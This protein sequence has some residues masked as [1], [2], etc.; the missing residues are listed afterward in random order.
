MG[1]GRAALV[2]NKHTLRERLYRL[3]LFHAG[4]MLVNTHGVQSSAELEYHPSPNPS[5]FERAWSSRL[6]TSE[7]SVS[8]HSPSQARTEH[9]VATYSPQELSTW[10]I[11]RETS[12]S[13]WTHSLQHW[14]TITQVMIRNGTEDK[15]TSIEVAHSRQALSSV[16]AL[17]DDAPRRPGHQIRHQDRRPDVR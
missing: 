16:E 17:R 11:P 3:A 15:Q 6:R 7:R 2:T 10:P 14:S 13:V 5:V 12:N 8:T 4:L 1:G 9:L